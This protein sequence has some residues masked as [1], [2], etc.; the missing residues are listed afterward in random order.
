[1]NK[2]RNDVVSESIPSKMESLNKSDI[3]KHKICIFNARASTLSNLIKLK[4]NNE[5]ERS[6]L[7][8]TATFI[9]DNIVNYRGVCSGAVNLAT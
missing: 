3:K 4:S 7:M 6:G 9:K 8:E 2:Y 5:Y 1:M